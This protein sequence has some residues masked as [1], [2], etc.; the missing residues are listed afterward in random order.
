MKKNHSEYNPSGRDGGDHGQKPASHQQGF[1]EPN[2]LEL[3][4]AQSNVI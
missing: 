4:R 1:E 3:R 2:N